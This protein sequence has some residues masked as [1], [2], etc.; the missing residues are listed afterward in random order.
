MRK[1]VWSFRLV[2]YNWWQDWFLPDKRFKAH[3]S[4]LPCLYFVGIFVNETTL[5]GVFSCVTVALPRSKKLM[6]RLG[7]WCRLQSPR[8]SQTPRIHV[9]KKRRLKGETL[10]ALEVR[11]EDLGR[12][13]VCA[14]C[15][16]KICGDLKEQQQ[17]STSNLSSGTYVTMIQFS[18]CV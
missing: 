12:Y 17:N 13:N 7:R 16:N 1:V 14:N 9:M 5:T 4:L 10:R 2:S 15:K 6:E 11:E 3:L 8:M 18:H